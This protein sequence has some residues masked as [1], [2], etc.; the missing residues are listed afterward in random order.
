[1]IA[2]QEGRP[3]K[4]KKEY[5]AQAIKL[6]KKGFIDP[7]IADFFDIALS[8]LSLWKN[9]HPEFMDALKSGKRHSDDKVV[10]ALY[11]RALG[12]E[13]TETKEE[14]GDAGKKSTL[15]TKKV[16]GDVG[17]MCFWLKNRQPTEWRDKQEPEGTGDTMTDAIN[18]LIDKLPN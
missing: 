14:T 13:V 8:T 9:A 11:N 7:E 15:I 18:K 2:K 3:T 1:M 16:A 4:Y 6:C 12:Y 10:D 5:C 17:A